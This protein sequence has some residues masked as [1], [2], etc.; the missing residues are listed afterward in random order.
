MSDISQID[1]SVIETKDDNQNNETVVSVLDS[2]MS[3]VEIRMSNLE[4]GMKTMN[5]NIVTLITKM[6]ANLDQSRQDKVDTNK[7]FTDI[8]MLID[9]IDIHNGQT[10]QTLEEVRQKV[11]EGPDLTTLT[12]HLMNT[13]HSECDVIEESLKRNMQ[14]FK[15]EINAVQSPFMVKMETD[16]KN[17]D[18]ALAEGLIAVHD[19]M[20]KQKNELMTEVQAHRPEDEDWDEEVEF[21]Q[22]VTPESAQPGSGDIEGVDSDYGYHMPAEAITQRIRPS[23]K[24]PALVFPEPGAEKVRHRDP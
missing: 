24:R 8:H 6:E 10:R 15:D 23:S 4:L 20:N 13:V 22:I 14:S 17:L 21:E 5:N 19:R 9:R 18:S 12:E 16:M 7:R 3:N 2:R 11:Q 1:I